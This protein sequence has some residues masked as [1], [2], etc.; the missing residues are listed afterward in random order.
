MNF[1]SI[2]VLGLSVATLGLSLPAHAGTDDT[3]TSVNS[4]QSAIITG[5]GNTTHQTNSTDVRN[6]QT[7]RRTSSGA[8]GTSVNSTQSADVQGYDNYTNQ[9]NSTSVTNSKRRSSSSSR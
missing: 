9:N 7:G 8:T 4:T 5:D 1:K 6:S 2:L 3:G